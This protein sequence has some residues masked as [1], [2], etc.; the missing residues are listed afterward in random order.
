MRAAISILVL[1]ALASLAASGASSP[2]TTS[3]ASKGDAEPPA[4]TSVAML[5]EVWNVDSGVL[6]DQ[7]EARAENDAGDAISTRQLLQGSEAPTTKRLTRMLVPAELS[8][9]SSFRS[10]EL[11]PF[12]TV[13]Q[14]SVATQTGFGGDSAAGT[15]LTF[16]CNLNASDEISLSLRL[17]ISS[18][19]G[20]PSSEAVPPPAKKVVL[21]GSVSAPSG[22]LRMF[23]SQSGD[24]LVVVF[25]KATYL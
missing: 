5:C 19:L 9:E 4:A 22:T 23:Q 20:Q 2:S 12:I 10:E 13:S 3:T 7:I 8:S 16:R 14:G 11:V 17:E 18:F 6:I 1:A 15:S 21:N 25:V 24:G